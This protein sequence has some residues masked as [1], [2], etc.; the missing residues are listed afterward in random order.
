MGDP[1]LP[2]ESGNR[3]VSSSTTDLLQKLNQS[4]KSVEQEITLQQAIVHMVNLKVLMNPLTK[5]STSLKF[6]LGF[7]PI[8]H[9]FH[10]SSPWRISYCRWETIMQ[11][12]QK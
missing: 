2:H 8:T 3:L 10:H 11:E 7:T 5:P 1:D 12:I 9:Y 4:I 6:S